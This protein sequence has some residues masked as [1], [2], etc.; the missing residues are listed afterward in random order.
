MANMALGWQQSAAE[1]GEEGG[2]TCH[3]WTKRRIWKAAVGDV[4]P[5][6]LEKCGQGL[7]ALALTETSGKFNT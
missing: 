3:T 2:D 4:V 6:R 5:G 7:A 1:I